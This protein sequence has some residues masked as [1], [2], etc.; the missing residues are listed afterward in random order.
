MPSSDNIQSPNWWPHTLMIWQ[1]L[2]FQ[3]QK[4]IEDDRGQLISQQKNWVTINNG[5][6]N[7]NYQLTVNSDK[8]FIQII[9]HKNIDKLPFQELIAINQTL[10]KNIELSQ[11]LPNCFFESKN[12]RIFEWLDEP[13][14]EKQLFDNKIF[15]NQI[16][17]FLFH[18]HNI[19]CAK[20]PKIDIHEHLE[21]YLKRVDKQTVALK[22]LDILINDA[23]KAIQYFQPSALCHHDL[24]PQ[25]ILYS[26]GLYILDWEYACVSDPFFDLAGLSINFDLNL[27]QENKL[28]KCY[29]KLSQLNYD[30][31]K[32]SAMKNLYHLI[33]KLWRM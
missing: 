20:F 27:Q 7:C 32:F 25:N 31:E 21:R 29:F 4:K 13:H 17:L 19:D 3:F 11:N 9:N 1:E 33:D 26:R 14:A 16:A 6:S 12:I 5:L 10:N 18:L 23:Q 22:Y 28:L 24:S 2:I 8:F 15:I 30:A